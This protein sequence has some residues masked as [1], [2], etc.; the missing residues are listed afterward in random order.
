MKNKIKSLDDLEKL[1]KEFLIPKDVAPIL[2]VDPYNIN[3][4]AKQDIERGVNSLGFPVIVIG[5][6][7]KIPKLA[8][9]K[10]MREGI[11][12]FESEEEKC[13]KMN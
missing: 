12:D 11:F 13:K 8:F 10:F 7:V 1:D 6:R 9:I 2:G 5:S 3:I 4:Q